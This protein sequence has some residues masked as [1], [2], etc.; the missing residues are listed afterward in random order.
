LGIN[1][2]PFLSAILFSLLFVRFVVR[3]LA[4]PG[5][6]LAIRMQPVF[7]LL[8]LVEIF[9]WFAGS[10]YGTGFSSYH[11]LCSFKV[12]IST[13]YYLTKLLS[14]VDSVPLG[15]L[16]ASYGSERTTYITARCFGRFKYVMEAGSLPR[17]R[18]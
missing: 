7:G 15:L 1:Y 13:P 3:F 9:D 10:A 4:F 17:M 16:L 8:L 18:R 14:C 12:I 5:A 6:H 2:L 11:G